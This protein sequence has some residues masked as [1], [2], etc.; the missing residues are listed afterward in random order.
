[1]GMTHDPTHLTGPVRA[2]GGDGPGV[3]IAVKAVPGA[4]RDQIA[5]VLGERLKV[6]ITAPPEDGKANDA[7]RRLL[8]E[9]LKLPISAVSIV[10]G[11]ARPEKTVRARGIDAPSARERLQ[12]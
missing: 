10:S 5:G 9:A 1:M 12:L 4:S 6:R 7:I 2:D 8:A 11:H 3:L